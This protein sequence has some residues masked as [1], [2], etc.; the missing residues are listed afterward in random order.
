MSPWAGTIIDTSR[1]NI[2]ATTK[3]GNQSNVIVVGAHS[4]SVFAGPGIEDDGSGSIGILA[5]AKALSFFT[6]VHAVRFIWFTAEEAGLYGSKSYVNHLDDAQRQAIDLYL[7]F[8]MI[9]SPNYMYAITSATNDE[10]EN[11]DDG[12]DN[13]K[14]EPF[15]VMMEDIKFTFKDFFENAHLNYTSEPIAP[16]TDHWPFFEDGISVGGLFTGADTLKSPEHAEMF[17]GQ[18]GIAYDACYHR[19]CDNVTNLSHEAFEVSARGIAFAV[20][21]Y[22]GGK[23]DHN[24]DGPEDPGVTV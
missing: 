4:D 10:D 17:G 13:D 18:A 7:N 15:Q 1:F 21:R 11:Y 19:A 5:V 3:L 22:A 16:N 12:N 2:I 24:I 23:Y 14:D 8:D 9:A 20:G 6:I